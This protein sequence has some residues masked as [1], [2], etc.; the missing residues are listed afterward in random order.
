MTDTKQTI[1]DA[2]AELGVTMTAEFV[3]WS[4]SR[5]KGEKHPSLNWVITL[6]KGGRAFLTT[7]YSAGCGHCPGWIAACASTR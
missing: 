2:A 1:V 6:H 7:D 3:P 5:D 4:K